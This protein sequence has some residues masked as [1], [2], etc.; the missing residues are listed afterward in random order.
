MSSLCMQQRRGKACSAS[1]LVEALVDAA[2]K[3]I[4]MY[5][6][7]WDNLRCSALRSFLKSG[8][9]WYINC[10]LVLE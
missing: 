10:K 9:E 1:V 3:L 6:M 2:A 4:Q 8:L 7:G 5:W